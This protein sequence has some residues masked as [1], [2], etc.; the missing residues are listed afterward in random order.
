MASI[1]RTKMND[2]VAD[3]EPHGYHSAVEIDEDVGSWRDWVG[4]AL[5]LL[6]LVGAIVVLVLMTNGMI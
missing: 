5:A 2:E 6:F 3:T 1:T 4:P